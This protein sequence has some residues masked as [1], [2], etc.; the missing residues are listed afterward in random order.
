MREDLLRGRGAT[1]DSVGTE[2]V[3]LAVSH[4]GSDHVEAPRCVGVLLPEATCFHQTAGAIVLSPADARVGQN[5][6][7]DL[8]RAKRTVPHFAKGRGGAIFWPAPCCYCDPISNT[9]SNAC[10]RGW[11]WSPRGSAF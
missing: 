8:P 11:P 2:V 10:G 7:T 5:G 4:R 6:I 1:V 9:S 3:F